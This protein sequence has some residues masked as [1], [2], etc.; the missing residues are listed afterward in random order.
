[1]KFIPLRAKYTPLLEYPLI[2]LF[3]TLSLVL[4]AVAA[5]VNV[6]PFAPPRLPLRVSP[7]RT[8]SALSTLIVIALPDVGASAAWYAGGEMMDTDL[9]IVNGPNPAE[10]R[11]ITSPPALVLEMATSNVR[12][13][14]GTVQVA[15]S[16]P[17]SDTAL[18]LFWAITDV[19]MKIDS[20]TASP[21]LGM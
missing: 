12:Q 9:L 13:G 1:M 6:I 7:R 11:T 4:L 10:E 20:R 8:T 5:P 18:R 3:Y 2:T 21:I 17:V 16:F 15:A 14:S 19:Q